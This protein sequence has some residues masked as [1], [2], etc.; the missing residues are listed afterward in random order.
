MDQ[1]LKDLIGALNDIQ[2][3]GTRLQ[4]MT[5]RAGSHLE[6]ETTQET[7]DLEETFEALDD[8]LAGYLNTLESYRSHVEQHVTT[9]KAELHNQNIRDL[10]NTS[11]IRNDT[12]ELSP[13]H[14]ISTSHPV[15]M[16][17]KNIRE[18][19]ALPGDII[20]RPSRHKI[21]SI[22]EEMGESITDPATLFEQQR[23]LARLIGYD[24]K[25]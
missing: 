25:V 16:F 21:I 5:K 6:Q 4:D 18:L 9:S 19:R 11:K 10:N 20:Q 1:Q 14:N 3:A 12:D 15:K 7:K 13:P 2:T 22:V 17:P 23:A 24:G 8:T